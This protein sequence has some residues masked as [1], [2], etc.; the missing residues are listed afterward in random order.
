M[1]VEQVYIKYNIM[2]GENFPLCDSVQGV[3]D[4]F[5]T[6]KYDDKIKHL[7]ISEKDALL[8]IYR[9][10]VAKEII[11]FKHNNKIFHTA[12][13]GEIIATDEAC[14]YSYTKKDWL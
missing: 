5:K 6:Y 7:C 11:N 3:L 14:V 1:R 8:V 4:V 2:E 13:P 9:H 10:E 12:K